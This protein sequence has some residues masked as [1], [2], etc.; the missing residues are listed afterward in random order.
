MDGFQVEE[1][2]KAI[3]DYLKEKIEKEKACIY[4]PVPFKVFKETEEERNSKA[5]R[6][7]GDEIRKEYGLMSKPYSN[8]TQNIL[9]LILYEGPMT[10]KK[11]SEKLK[12]N[13]KSVSS[14]M[15][16][17]WGALKDVC[18]EREEVGKGYSYSKTDGYTVTK[19][20]V[21][22]LYREVRAYTLE[23]IKV[24]K[25]AE[26][27]TPVETKEAQVKTEV[28]SESLQEEIKITVTVQGQINFI[29][30]LGK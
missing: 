18:L 5:K 28:E 20:T 29:F 15:T 19:H 7:E 21:E 30:S 16:Y 17:I 25:T 4:R 3:K 6:L 27:A 26:K 8:L 12:V 23:R 11:M 22:D 1:E 2:K 24:R 10:N 9:Y 13:T 14:A